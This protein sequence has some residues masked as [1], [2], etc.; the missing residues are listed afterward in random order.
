[1]SSE[2]M[3][4]LFQKFVTDSEFGTGLELYITKKLVEAHGGRNR[5]LIMPMA[6]APLLYLAYQITL[7][8]IIGLIS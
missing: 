5:L 1:M 7:E 4:K 6:M 3:S 2:I 8:T